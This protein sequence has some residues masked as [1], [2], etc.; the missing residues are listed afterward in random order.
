MPELVLQALDLLQPVA[1]P[2]VL[3]RKRLTATGRGVLI[4]SPT[5]C[6]KASRASVKKS[7]P[8]ELL[9][10]YMVFA[11]SAGFR[12]VVEDLAADEADDLA[13]VTEYELKQLPLRLEHRLSKGRFTVKRIS[14][15]E[16]ALYDTVTQRARFGLLMEI[17]ADI[18][19][20]RE[21]GNLPPR[22]DSRW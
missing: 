7:F 16:Y 13:Y 19:H 21:T 12:L 8:E 3:K 11:A 22:T 5:E 9:S 6:A 17:M 15:T 14:R 10:T 20:V 1:E 18:G 2:L 4:V